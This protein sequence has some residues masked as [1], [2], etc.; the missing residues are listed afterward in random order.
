M[1]VFASHQSLGLTI[2]SP[3]DLSVP[4]SLP[5]SAPLS[6]FATLGVV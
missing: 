4:P 3:G 2:L 1:L 5:F 6:P